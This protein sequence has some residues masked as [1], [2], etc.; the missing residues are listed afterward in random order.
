MLAAAI[1]RTYIGLQ[2]DHSGVFY[3]LCQSDWEPV[4]DA[5]STSVA[6]NASLPCRFDIP[7]PAGG[8]EIDFSAVNFVYTPQGGGPTTI[9]YV[10][11]EGG[12]GADEG[13][14]YDDPA[15]PAQIVACPA[16]CA[17]FEGAEGQVD[18]AFGCATL[19]E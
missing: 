5:L 19:L 6:A 12:C 8:D 11:G 17:A 1:G 4:F 16:T 15:A 18:V 3:S 14:Y 9:P 10:V 2:E 7:E 13:W